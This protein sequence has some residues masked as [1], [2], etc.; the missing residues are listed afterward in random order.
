MSDKEHLRSKP[1]PETLPL[2]YQE[3][4]DRLG[5]QFDQVNAIDSKAGTMIGLAGGLA[6]IA[7]F[8]VDSWPVPVV[9]LVPMILAM[10]AVRIRAYRRDPDPKALW[11]HYR[12]EEQGVVME[13]LISNWLQC[14]EKNRD[15]IKEKLR[16]L[17]GAYYSFAAIVVGLVLWLV[18]GGDCVG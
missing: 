12:K 17:R 3:I 4:K 7:G 2:I 10:L 11:E 1:D 14:Y 8:V 13:Q 6:A 18:W 5:A 9:L 16:W 15:G